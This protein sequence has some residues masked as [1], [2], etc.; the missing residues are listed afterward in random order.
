MYNGVCSCIFC[1]HLLENKTM[2]VAV[3]PNVHSLRFI[4]KKKNIVLFVMNC[5]VALG[6]RHQPTS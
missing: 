5:M 3:S 2:N 4:Q 6:L 1:I